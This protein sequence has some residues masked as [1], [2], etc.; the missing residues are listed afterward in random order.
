MTT[1]CT[2]GAP[3]TL[4]VHEGRTFHNVCDECFQREYEQDTESS[5]TWEVEPLTARATPQTEHPNQ[6]GGEIK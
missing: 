3:A 4:T 1:F 6:N 2:C 5:R